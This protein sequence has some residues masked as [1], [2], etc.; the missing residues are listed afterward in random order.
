[1]LHD[2]LGRSPA[3]DDSNFVA[4]SADVIGDVKLG[5]ESSV[6][7]N[8]TVRGDVNWIR[9]GARSN[10]QDGCVIHVTNA[11]GP[12]TIGAEVTLGHGAIVHG[13]EVADRVLEGMGAVV[14][15][16]AR[17]GSDVLI[18]A[19]S[20]VTKGTVIPERSLV[21]GSP[22]RVVR[23]LTDEEVA[24]VRGYADHYVRYSRIY[25]GIDEPTT[26]PFYDPS[27]A[28]EAVREALTSSAA[29]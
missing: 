25:L 20:L 3:V 29:R 8:A 16:G 27:D 1:M 14:L 28:P 10:V 17:I 26:N 22:A 18:G 13:C 2:F 19:R 21:L 12:T 23:S 7:F 24:A 5:S 9:I 15:D 11:T 6:W 4:P